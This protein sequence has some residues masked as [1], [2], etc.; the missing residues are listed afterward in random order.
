[1]KKIMTK[2]VLSVLAA[3][4][5]LGGVTP[6]VLA[7]A[8]NL[9]STS[10]ENKVVMDNEI[11][12]YSLK[13]LVEHDRA[14]LDFLMKT[15]ADH[16]Y[17]VVDAISLDVKFITYLNEHPDKWAEIYQKYY[18]D[19]YLELRHDDQ[20]EGFVS[21]SQETKDGTVSIKGKV[22]D[23]ITKVEVTAP[24]GNK[25]E[26]VPNS[27]KTFAVSFAATASATP[28]YATLNAYAG[29]KLVKTETLLINAGTVV[30]DAA[31]KFASAVYN[32][33]KKEVKV[34]GLVKQ[35]VDKVTVTYGDEEM[36]AVLY[37]LWDGFGSFSVTFKADDDAKQADVVA[38]KNGVKVDEENVSIVNMKKPAPVTYAIK[39]TASFSPKNKVVSVKGSVRG[40]VGGKTD[41]LKLYVIAPDGR[42]QEVG[43]K[44]DGSFEASIDYKNRSF[45]SKV[46]R[47]EL[48]QEGKRVAQANVPYTMPAVPAVVQPKPHIQPGKVEI[49]VNGKWKKDD[50]FKDNDRDDE[51]DHDDDN[52]HGKENG[53]GKGKGHE[54][55]DD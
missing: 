6:A 20:K 17:L 40:L 16:L 24:N 51:N 39:A 30:D 2:P 46:I 36:N 54:K 52:D 34:T 31:I 7:G 13:E 37:K 53:H 8:D 23:E 45:S 48:Y 43:L 19:I 42:K 27:D 32:E 25:I 5:I 11:T 29:D 22:T 33:T 18:D 14:K 50:H 35:G 3:A 1:M 44:A 21:F 26:V 15:E 10:S 55:H 9:L 49:K 4:T 47:V 41:G 38:Y 12:R 28:Q